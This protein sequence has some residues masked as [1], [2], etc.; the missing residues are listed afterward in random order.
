MEGRQEGKREGWKAS[1]EEVQIYS[2]GCCLLRVVSEGLG[3]K[4]RI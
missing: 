3:E 1:Y 2:R 4:E